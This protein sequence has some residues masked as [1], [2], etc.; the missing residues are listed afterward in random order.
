MTGEV[1]LGS[2]IGDHFEKLPD[3]DIQEPPYIRLNPKI[4]TMGTPNKDSHDD[5]STNCHGHE[6]G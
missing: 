5:N 6:A 3:G 4:L 2:S 1:F